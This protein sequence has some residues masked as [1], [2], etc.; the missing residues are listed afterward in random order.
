MTFHPQ[1]HA[2]GSAHWFHEDGW[3]SFNMFQNG[4]CRNTPVYDKIKTL[5]DRRPVKPVLDGEPLYEDHPVCFNA[6][7]LGTSNACDVRMFAYLDVFA[8]AFG[9][10]YGSP[11][12]LAVLRPGQEGGEWPAHVLEAGHGPAG[13]EADGASQE[14]DRIR[15][16]G[17]ACAG[18]G[19]DQGKRSSGGRA[20]TRLPG[21]GLCLHI[22]LRGQ[23]VYREPRPDNRHHIAIRLV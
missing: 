1:P 15:P 17:R 6:A 4:H 22:Q 19:P 9:H 23:A 8:G 20:H 14:V 2:S 21:P 5:Y 18:P 16:G 10:T 3:L 13:S 12:H 7:D 11:R